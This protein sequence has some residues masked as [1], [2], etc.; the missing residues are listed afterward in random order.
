MTEEG[1]NPENWVFVKSNLSRACR[2]L[3]SKYELNDSFFLYFSIKLARF[4]IKLTQTRSF[5]LLDP[6]KCT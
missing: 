4:Q 1:R 2:I 3:F 5:S 6:T